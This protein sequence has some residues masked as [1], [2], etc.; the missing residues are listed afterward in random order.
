MRYSK[1]RADIVLQK[2]EELATKP[3]SKYT[4]DSFCKQH[5]LNSDGDVRRI[6]EVVISCP[7]HEDASPSLSMNESKRRWH[8][9]S[10]DRGGTFMSLVYN[11]SRLVMGEDVSFY[12]KLNEVLAADIELQ[13]RVGFSSLIERKTLFREFTS[14]TKPNVRLNGSKAPDSFPE[15]SSLMMKR[16]CSDEEKRYAIL[17][18][19]KGLDVKFVYDTIFGKESGGT[20][21]SHQYSVEEL[22]KE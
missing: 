9:F 6:S 10:C 22:N 16:E 19:Q 17:L 4:F 18:M 13:D 11:Y 12:Q 3:G 21:T 14:V 5:N 15:L 20:E 7:F 2:I 1:E 8:C